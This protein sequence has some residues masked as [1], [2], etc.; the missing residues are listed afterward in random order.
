MIRGFVMNESEQENV[1]EE[2]CTM[3]PPHPSDSGKGPGAERDRQLGDPAGSGTAGKAPEADRRWGHVVLGRPGSGKSM[4]LLNRIFQQEAG[5]VPL[6]L[7]TPIDEKRAVAEE[8]LDPPD[9]V[10]FNPMLRRPH[11]S[12]DQHMEAVLDCFRATLG[13]EPF[14]SSQSSQEDDHEGDA[15]SK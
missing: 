1:M 2:D 6:I 5:N 14:V 3:N 10:V 7:L 13:I 11:I 15:S 8:R 9:T 12:F 4:A